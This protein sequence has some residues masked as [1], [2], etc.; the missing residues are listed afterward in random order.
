MSEIAVAYASQT[1]KITIRAKTK[2][3]YS[4]ELSHVRGDRENVFEDVTALAE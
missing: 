3:N 4:L 1:G 2:A